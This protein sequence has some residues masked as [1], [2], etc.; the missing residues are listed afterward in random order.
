MSSLYSIQVERHVIAALFKFP[1]LFA[2]V[3]GFLS[4]NEFV[5]DTHRIIFSVIKASLSKGE[6]IDKV[7]VAQKIKNLGIT[8]KDDIEIFGYLDAICSSQINIDG[9]KSSCK[10]LVKLRVR[11]EIAETAEKIKNYAIKCGDASVSD[12]ITQ[13]DKI[14]NERLNSYVEDS[15]PIDLFGNIEELIQ[16]RAKNPIQEAGLI[17]PFSKFNH[18]FGGVR[19]GN[20][21]YCIVSRPG[22]GK[23]TWLLN[24]AQGITMLNENTIALY[25]DTEMQTEVNQFR[26]VSA[27]SQVPMWYVE[28][29]NW[30]KSSEYG[31]RIEKTT[32]NYKKYKGKIFHKTVANKPIEYVCSLIR[33]FYYKYI[34]RNTNKKLIV[35]YDYIKLTGEK[36]DQNWA[37]HQA[38]GSKIDQLNEVGKQLDIQIFA[39]MQLNRSAEEGRDDSAAIAISDRLQWFAALV[40]IFRRKTLEEM[41]Q[42]GVEFGSHKLIPLKTR[43]QGRDSAGHHDMV[44]VSVGKEKKRYQINFISFDVRNFR[45]EERGTLVDIVQRRREQYELEQEEE[46]EDNKI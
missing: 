18:L 27:E 42:D 35:I 16:E 6:K 45:V 20:G 21:L 43:F 10:E 37:E 39:A 44:D 8:L 9:G 41:A 33:R 14:Y 11:R 7:V 12:I 23:S 40:A 29:G 1:E 25:L 36:I 15:E 19:S 31:K 30:A 32:P 26:A 34:G 3:D 17:T 2:D 38:I 24:I 4:E 13:S 46:T 5:N 22:H 28:T